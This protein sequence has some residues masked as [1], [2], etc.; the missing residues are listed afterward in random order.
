MLNYAM[1]HNE[2]GVLKVRDT[3]YG[4]LVTMYG[5]F[6]GGRSLSEATP[7]IPGILGFIILLLLLPPYLRLKAAGYMAAGVALGIGVGWLV[8]AWDWVVPTAIAV[9]ALVL[10]RGR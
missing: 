1:P 5:Y 2:E 7:I 3:L 4:L 9:L 10:T 6:V 8:P